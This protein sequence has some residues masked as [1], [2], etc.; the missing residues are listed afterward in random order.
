MYLTDDVLTTT[1]LFRNNEL[2]CG[3]A[4]SEPKG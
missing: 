4:G 3:D 1:S 2:L